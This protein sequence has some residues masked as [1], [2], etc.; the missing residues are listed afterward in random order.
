MDLFNR[1]H[2]YRYVCAYTLPLLRMFLRCV[3]RLTRMSVLFSIIRIVQNPRLLKFAY[4]CVVFYVTCWVILII[5]KVVQCASD[6][7]WHHDL[8]MS[9]KPFC[10]VKAQISIFEFTGKHA[11]CTSANPQILII[12]DWDVQPIVSQSRSSSCFLFGC[13]GGLNYLDAR[14]E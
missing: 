9:G 2:L 8:V 12:T 4:A 6:P 1:L 7:S 5:E 11:V 3:F 13:C 14:G 10:M